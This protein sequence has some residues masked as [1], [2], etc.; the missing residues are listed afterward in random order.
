[1][2]ERERTTQTRPT[3]SHVAPHDIILNI[4]QMRDAIHLQKFRIVSPELDE[5]TIITASAIREKSAAPPTA[6]SKTKLTAKAKAT[7]HGV[8][9]PRRVSHL[10]QTHSSHPL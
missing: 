6:S 1:M 8:A 4:A 9:Q 3:V 7:A 10:Q 5:D 2:Q